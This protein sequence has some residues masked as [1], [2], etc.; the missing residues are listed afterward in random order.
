[1][2]QLA[3]SGV[4]AHQN[5]LS[6]GISITKRPVRSI[7]R[8]QVVAVLAACVLAGVGVPACAQDIEPRA[9]SNAPVGVNFLIAGYAYTRGGL[10]F[11]T[12]VPV[13]NPDLHTSNAVLAYARVLDLWG[14]SGKVDVIVPY[15]W[16]SGTADF[17][18]ESVSRTVNG[19]GNPL[20]RLSVNL[21]GAPALTLKEFA[22]YQQDL[23]VGASL[24]I[25]APWSQYDSSRVVNIGTNRWFFK[26]EVGVSK[27]VGPWTV[28]FS[29][30]ATLYTDN[31]DF[32][33]GNKRSQD[34]IYSFQGHAIYAF[35]SGIWGSLDATYFIG[36]RTTINDV[37]NYDLQQN[38]RVG[39]TLAL[40]VDRL[41]SVKLYASSGVS[42][43]TGNNFDL[44]GIAWQYRFGGG[45]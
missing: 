3:A 14:K 19:F 44:V 9:Y 36:G 11:D 39:A 30:A 18:G 45:L 26:P 34:P 15:T 38:W 7:L 43:R 25:S 21:Y 23:I 31:D 8:E 37:R 40:P 24:Q 12:S 33:G 22:G 28:E 1:L 13:T 6:Q 4:A 20:F 42:A 5:R 27:A 10:S 35:L 17:Q 2:Q 16:L 32:Y 41:N 29:A